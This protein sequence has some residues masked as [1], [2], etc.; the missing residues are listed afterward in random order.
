MRYG[1]AIAQS[2]RKLGHQMILTTRKHPDTKDLMRVLGERFEVV[3]EYSPASL[4]TR[5]KASIE[6][7]LLFLEMFKESK[8]D[9]AISHGSVELCRVGYGLDMRIICTGDTTYTKANPLIVPLADTMIISKAIPRKI[10]RK[11]GARNI[12]QFNGVD[13]VAWVKPFKPRKST[14]HEHPLIVVRQSE[15]KAS[16]MKGV[17][18]MLDIARKLT[19]LG[20]VLFLPRYEK[21]KID[22]VVV[23]EEF[24]D[25]LSLANEADLVVG[26]GGTITREAALQGTPSLVI[27]IL[28]WSYVNDYVAKMGFPL[29]KVRLKHVL[30]YAKKHLGKHED[31]SNILSEMENPVDVIETL[32]ESTSISRI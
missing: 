25:S 2:L 27:P 6:R 32:V 14:K 9:I 12:I 17:D 20:K 5:F 16:Y 1:H 3:G 28:G 31:V 23:P 24:V 22:G 30:R 4:T 13:E 10:Y 8:P 11:Y 19:S 21:E 18:V 15:F 26:V 7:E 29:F